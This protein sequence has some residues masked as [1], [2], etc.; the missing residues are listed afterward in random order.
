MTNERRSSGRRKFGYYM[1]V[2]DNRNG[3]TIGYLANISAQGFKLESPK[4]ISTDVIFQM[5]MDLTPEISKTKFITFNA[6][7]IWSQ[8][9]PIAPMEYTHGF[10]IVSM[11]PDA[12]A[13]FESIAEKYGQP[14]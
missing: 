13:I 5:R 11:A 3:D 14:E 2:F 9:D 1:P 4:K 10:Q 7:A 6:K 12:R 8:P